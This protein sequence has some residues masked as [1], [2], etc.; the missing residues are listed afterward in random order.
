[1]EQALTFETAILKFDNSAILILGLM[2]SRSLKSAWKQKTVKQKSTEGF[3]DPDLKM[4][5]RSFK[6]LLYLRDR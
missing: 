5:N 6:D 3:F 2:E 1:M 4:T